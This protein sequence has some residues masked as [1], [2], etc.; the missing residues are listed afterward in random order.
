MVHLD[1]I[2]IYSQ[3][4]REH[5]KHLSLVFQKLRENKL[6]V[7]KEKCEFAQRQIT[8]LGHKI[9]E[10]PF[11]KAMVRFNNNTKGFHLT[12]KLEIETMFF[13]RVGT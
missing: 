7:K 9:G 5:E 2:V 3:S 13:V 1:D 10:D 8:F 12:F 6:F 4:L 11:T